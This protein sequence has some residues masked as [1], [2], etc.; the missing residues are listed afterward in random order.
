MPLPE[1]TLLIAGAVVAG[2]VQGLA[3]FGFSMVAMSFWVWGLAP[4]LAAAMAVFGSLVG[5]L[6]AAFSVPRAWSVALLAPFVAGGLVG[7]PLGVWALPH[8]D[9]HLFKLVLGALLV[10]A[11]PAMLMAARLPV[12]APRAPGALR[13]ADGLA[14]AAGGFMGGLGGFTG[15]VPSL[16]CSLRGLD[17]GAQRGV[18]QNFNLATLAV[19]MAAYV[20]TGAITRP[21]WPLLPVVAAALALPSLVG[22]RAYRRLSEQ[23]FRQV[24]LGLLTL[25]GAAMLA[26]ALPRVWG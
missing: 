8:L 17:K 15:V 25:S 21:M 23:R 11:C 16:W 20:A 24:V 2:F 3:G 18:I 22:A 4:P 10:L 7:I 26:T 1:L 9:A 13:L 5:Q 14:G 12:L 6:I 19:T